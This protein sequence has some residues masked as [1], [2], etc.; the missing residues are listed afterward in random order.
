MCIIWCILAKLFPQNKDRD[1]IE[2]YKP[3]INQIVNVN[4]YSYPISLKDI[5][6]LEEENNLKINIFNYDRG[7]LPIRISNRF[8]VCSDCKNS[9]DNYECENCSKRCIDL[10]NINDEENRSA[11]ARV[12]PR[13]SDGVDQSVR[14]GRRAPPVSSY[15]GHRPWAVR[16]FCAHR[17]TTCI[18]E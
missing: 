8:I 1:N 17:K 11:S 15:A 16:T 13:W 18:Y 12:Q 4:S 14:H 3:Y 9:I 2:L 10:L 5:D 7:L 6:R